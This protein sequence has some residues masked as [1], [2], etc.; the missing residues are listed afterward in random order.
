MALK[1]GTRLGPY[2]ITSAIGAGA[3]GEVYCARDTKLNRE[4]AVKVLPDLFAA[5]PEWL[6]R[7]EREARLLASL[8][9]RH[10]AQVYGFEEP[11]SG[12]SL[13]AEGVRSAAADGGHAPHRAARR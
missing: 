4:V 10:I 5:D 1:P 9:H 12:S 6:G 8:N 3:M 11:P 7:F 13:S 2:E